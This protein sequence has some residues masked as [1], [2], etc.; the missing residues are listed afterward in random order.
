MRPSALSPRAPQL[1]NPMWQAVLCNDLSCPCRGLSLAQGGEPEID[2]VARTIINDWQR[3]KL[4]FFVP[5]PATPEDGPVA[6]AIKDKKARKAALAADGAVPMASEVGA[7]QRMK[8]AVAGVVDAVM[9]ADA[10][11]EAGAGSGADAPAGAGSGAGV[12]AAGDAAGGARA[13]AGKKAQNLKKRGRE[14]EAEEQEEES[15]DDDDDDDDVDEEGDDDGDDDDEEEEG[16]GSDSDSEDKGS[17]RKGKGGGG[18]AG[19]ADDADGWNEF[20]VGE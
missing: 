9:A 13:A 1:A 16:E 2:V 14:E 18:A 6:K 12:A 7:R 19:A 20:D 11:A 4:P 5:P 17:K 10:T 3:G 8:R 15:D